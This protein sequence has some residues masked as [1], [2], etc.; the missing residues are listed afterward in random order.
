MD[1]WNEIDYTSLLYNQALPLNEPHRESSVG[2]TW[3][4]ASS[5][6]QFVLAM[7]LN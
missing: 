2:F 6:G 1:I 5:G 3:L 4:I 7:K